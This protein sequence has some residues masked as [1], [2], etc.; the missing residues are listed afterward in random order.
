M[1]KFTILS[2]VNGR[3]VQTVG[4]AVCPVSALRNQD[5]ELASPT[6]DGDH[7]LV[8]VDRSAIDTDYRAMMRK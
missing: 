4:Y 8:F 7:G 2:L 6:P 1:N 5:V 3:Y